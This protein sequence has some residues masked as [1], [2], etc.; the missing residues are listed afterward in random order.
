MRLNLLIFL[1]GLTAA[2]LVPELNAQPNL[3]LG[4][5][6]LA[7]L[8]TSVSGNTPSLPSPT[9]LLATNVSASGFTA[10]WTTVDNATGYYL[11]VSAKADFGQLAWWGNVGNTTSS[12]VQGGGVQPSTKY[13]YRVS[14]SNDAGNSAPSSVATVTTDPFPAPLVT[15]A[16][17]ITVNGFT[18][19]WIPVPE[20]NY[21][22]LD[23]ST[24]PDF[25][26]LTPRGYYLG[27]G[28]ATSGSINDAVW[29]WYSGPGF[30]Q[31][32]T[33]YYYRV[34]AVRDNVT[35]PY[36][37]T[38]T[39]TTAVLSA[40]QVQGTSNITFSNFTT[41][42][43]P[44]ANAT[45][46]SIDVS[47]TPD[48]G[49][50][51]IDNENIADNTTTSATVDLKYNIS[52]WWG[53]QLPPDATYYYRIRADN[54]GVASPNSTTQVITTPDYAGPEL[55]VA[56]DV[57]AF[58]FTANWNAVPDATDYTLE[59]S[60]T[61]DFGLNSD[62]ANFSIDLRSSDQTS[63]TIAPPPYYDY[64]DP[65]IVQPGSTYYYRVFATDGGINSLYSNV[66]SVTTPLF[67]APPLSPASN[68]TVNSFTANWNVLPSATG[69]DLYVSSTADFGNLVFSSHIRDGNTTSSDVGTPW[70]EGV[71]LQPGTTYYY[72]VRSDNGSFTSANSTTQTITT[73]AFP[74]P[75]V[76]N[77]TNIGPNYFTVNWA[78]VP[79]ATDYYI[80]IS[81]TPDFSDVMTRGYHLGDGNTTS[82]NV[83]PAWWEG[84]PLQPSTTYYYRVY[85]NG[86]NNAATPY[87]AIKS[88][89][90]LPFPAPQVSAPTNITLNSFTAGWSPVPGATGYSIVV[91]T[92]SGVSND[93]AY[94]GYQVDGNTTS[95]AWPTSWPYALSPGTTYYYC[96][97]ALAPNDFFS[98]A[99]TVFS[100]TTLPFSTPQLSAPANITIGSFTASWS[101]VPGAESYSIDVSTTSDFGNLVANNVEIDG[102][103]STVV[104]ATGDGRVP[105]QPG[106][107][108]FYRVRAN[109]SNYSSADSNTQTI[110]TLAFAA[111]SLNA[112]TN[113]TNN[114]FTA[115]WS[116]VANATGYSIDV[117]TTSNFTTLV[118]NNQ[119]VDGGNTTH[120]S[121]ISPDPTQQLP[122]QSGTSY[123]YRVR[124]DG[125]NVSS[126]N[127]TTRTIATTTS[128]APQ[129]GNATN[130]SI[131][132]FTL[133]WSALAGATGYYVDFSTTPNF[134]NI[135]VSNWYLGDG[136]TTS[137]NINAFG[138]SS[139]LIQ[140]GTT[141][142]YRLHATLANFSSPNSATQSV[143]TAAF[144]APTVN[145][146]T[147]IGVDSFNLNWSAV[148]GATSYYVDFST[149]SDFR[150]PLVSNLYVGDGAT[151][152]AYIYNFG[153]WSNPIHP[154][155][156]Y[157]YRLHAATDNFSS[158]YSTTQSVATVAL[159]APVVDAATNITFDSFTVNWE[160][161]AGVDNYLIDVSTTPNFGNLVL[162][163]S[164]LGN[165]NTTSRNIYIPY[166]NNY[167]W[168]S[169]QPPTLQPNTT[170]YYRI[171]A[172]AGN[173]TSPDSATQTVTTAV[174][175]APVATAAANVTFDGFTANWNAVPGAAS[176]SA[177]VST[178]ADFGNLVV[179]DYYLGNGNTTSTNIGGGDFFVHAGNNNIF[180]Y[181]PFTIQPNTTYYYRI[182]AQ[183]DNFTSPTSA[184]QTITTTTFPI[185]Q[186]AAAT[187]ITFYGFTANWIPVPGA[188]GYTM[189]LST[190]PDFG[191]LVLSN[192]N[193]SDDGNATS[194]DVN[195]N[196]SGLVIVGGGGGNL[197]FGGG[198]DTF[199]GGVSGSG[200]ILSGGSSFSL[201]ANSSEVTQTS[202]NTGGVMPALSIPNAIQ[203]DTTYYYRIRANA[204]G[205]IFSGNSATQTVTTTAFPAPQA[206]AATN[207]TVSSFTANWN[208]A[209]GATGYS[210]DISLTPD[211]GNLVANGLSFGDSNTTSVDTSSLNTSYYSWFFQ[212]LTLQPGTTYYYRIYAN[213]PNSSFS[214]ASATQTI[215]TAAFPYPTLDAATN[216]TSSSFT[217]NWETVPG[218]TGY[219]LDVSTTAD[220]GNLVI[221]GRFLDGGDTQ[222]AD[223]LTINDQWSSVIIQPSTT[224]YYR[225]YAQEPDFSTQPSTTGSITTL[226]YAPPAGENAANVTSDG[227][228]ASWPAVPG[229][230]S[231]VLTVSDT[232]D[233]SNIVF[234]AA[235]G[236][237]TSY[238][239]NDLQAG[240]TYYYQVNAYSPLGYSGY[241]SPANTTT[242][243]L[244]SSADAYANW[245]Q[246]LDLTG[247]NALPNAKPFSDG[248][249]N[250]AR[251]A[252]NL[253]R[254]PASR[255]L[256]TVATTY[257]TGANYL[258]LQ[259]RQRKSLN[260]YQLAP[261]SSTDLVHWTAVP[262]A[263][264]TQLTDDDV[265]TARYEA[266]VAIPPNGSIYLRVEVLPAQ[267]N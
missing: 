214:S 173:F 53:Q 19:N 101:A 102:G 132:S 210:I 73:D 34:Y 90:T 117:A 107:T 6:Q 170:Y 198:G 217:A 242:V 60:T 216:I 260:G 246:S 182:Y 75:L 254:R 1:S 40:P 26:N 139:T 35:S 115:N 176:Y 32:D 236:N 245:T 99:S 240:L 151:T 29:Y 252:M 160:P 250:M 111:P 49:N 228:T 138:S 95:A 190:T 131:N 194:S 3:A 69:Y 219:S 125:P 100:F 7:V 22:L 235:V 133:N 265:N 262:P 105:I 25:G 126:A 58:G 33:T 234:S 148:T 42:W 116:R 221:Q 147:N 50:L 51:V 266:C 137:A 179:S 24:T 78:A 80:D 222:S 87:S 171:Y 128:P 85:A 47:T 200:V 201:I 62:G 66:Q 23:V 174:L 257:R 164:S 154:G 72:S 61:P 213:G 192:Y 199:G 146:S 157:F 11:E 91:S 224:Y 119:Y 227:F 247:A 104:G 185:P 86:A 81:Q 59:I 39:L 212:P 12:G 267:K 121:V 84:G 89:T 13:Y 92:S 93:W 204:N 16:T 31:P 244:A 237:T 56:T 21:Y 67:T 48:F 94:S 83:N 68:I 218:A 152:S 231:Y 261:Q 155:T 203:P 208:P 181:E 177:D 168:W 129:M 172:Q 156:T 207:I 142:Y 106:T 145:A 14:A 44:V 36:S 264:I 229:A 122:I 233:F 17:D 79:E 193:L 211:F 197:T 188:D 143:T 30:I 136:T 256:P 178:T 230:S 4:F 8:Q 220:F 206:G 144:N 241:S 187:N 70:W 55:N 103:T 134:N 226:A 52:W 38:Q 183:G 150:H 114:G 113:I 41:T 253:D 97:H 43:S 140:P 232:A 159:T 249:T 96:V 195:S 248:L 223:I 175:S 180:Y 9:L 20:A 109:E 161:I 57:S 63:Y 209:P 37:A 120:A 251:Y 243:A 82:S 46:Y 166:N 28:N 158:P 76:N 153:S 124:A 149:T 255:E 74:A 258:T 2:A 135:L 196:D 167:Y 10:S 45:G 110:T 88:I 238:T 225:V 259:Y 184:T 130:V 123:F 189:D 112:I 65:T 165:G 5:T 163:G 169:P 162:S 191:N 98:P 54:F 141:Y 263:N 18:V 186:A 118:I 127:S 77:A 27:D 15:D 64:W 205:G 71:T 108:Y 239:V 202:G 215:T